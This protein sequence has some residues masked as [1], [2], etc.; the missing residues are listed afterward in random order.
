MLELTTQQQ[1]CMMKTAGC[2]TAECYLETGEDFL[3]DEL[4]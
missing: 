3:L 1:F 4:K 2:T